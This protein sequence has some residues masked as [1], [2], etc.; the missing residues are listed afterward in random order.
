MKHAIA[1]ILEMGN[2]PATGRALYQANGAAATQG[3]MFGWGTTVGNGI[4]GWAKGALF[5]DLDAA[6]GARLWYNAGTVGT[7]SWVAVV[8]TDA[9]AT[10][11]AAITFGAG[12]TVSTGQTAAV[13]DA[14]TLTVGGLIVPQDIDAHFI[15]AG[16]APATAGNFGVCF[17]TARAAC[18]ITSVTE[19][20]ATAGSDGGAVT[21]MLKKVP[22]GT[23][24]GSG[25]DT[26]TAGISLKGTA[27]TNAAGSLHGTVGNLQLA[28]GDSL[29][30]VLTGTPTS[31][32]G[33][34]VHVGLKRI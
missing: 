11:S 34:S 4:Q 12:F 27:D 5:L 33:L 14:D 9:V 17:W 28:A 29:A 8:T 6:A 19:R 7:A 16:S 25:T 21:G 31:L 23:A 3:R 32:A 2:L 18:Q 24:A 26:L 13:T 10:F 20:H 30:F 22:S 1:E 15:L